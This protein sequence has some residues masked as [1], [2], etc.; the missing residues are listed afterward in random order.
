ME[1][2]EQAEGES[3]P[4]GLPESAK[5]TPKG[6]GTSKGGF[7]SEPQKIARD[8]RRAGVLRRQFLFC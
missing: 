1:S 4:S 2:P 3:E 5:R 8:C 6:V 7:L